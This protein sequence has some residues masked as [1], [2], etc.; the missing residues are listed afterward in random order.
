MSIINFNYFNLDRC[1]TKYFY[2]RFYIINYTNTQIL[3]F[4]NNINQKYTI[5]I[6]ANNFLQINIVFLNILQFYLSI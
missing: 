5:N 2:R 6:I 1:I 4:F 3:I